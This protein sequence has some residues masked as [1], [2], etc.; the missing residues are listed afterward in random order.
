MSAPRRAV[1][2]RCCLVT[3][4][5][6]DRAVETAARA[7]AAG[8]GVV[9]V[10]AKEATARGLMELARQVA[11]AVAAASPRTRVLVN[12][13]ADVAWALARQ[14]E[15]V[16]GVH[17]GQDDLPARDARALLGPRALIGMTAGTLPLVRRAQD[18]AGD[19]DYLGAGPFRPTPTKPSRRVPLGVGGYRDL[20]AASA[21]P[22]VAIGNVRPDDVPALAA[23]GV[24][25][26]AMVR[27]I[28]AA[29]DPAVEVRRCLAGWS[30]PQD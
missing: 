5:T 1:D 13:R 20:V 15:A 26:T 21:L 12:D 19:I 23:T 3:S 16:H 8:A 28:M 10:R 14:G 25:G 11:R 30:V 17:L 4:G 6:G 24:A 29:P 18:L 2:L 22:I 27:A 7:A 9:Q